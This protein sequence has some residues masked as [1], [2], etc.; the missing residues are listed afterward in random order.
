M[1]NLK[2]SELLI[3]ITYREM[4]YKKEEAPQVIYKNCRQYVSNRHRCINC[5]ER[6]EWEYEC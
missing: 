6:L 4:S 1:I 2:E 5:G 3:K